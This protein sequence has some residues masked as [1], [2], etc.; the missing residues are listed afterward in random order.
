MEEKKWETYEE[1]AIYL[2][3]QFA[4]KFNLEYFEK[5]QIVEGE[6]S[7]TSWEIDGKGIASQ[8][9]KFIIVECRRYTKSKQNQEK[10]GALAYRILDTGASGGILVSPLGL[11]EG[12]EKVAKAEKIVSVR[13]N[14]NCTTKEYMLSFLNQIAVGLSDGVKITDSC[15][16]EVIRNGRVVEE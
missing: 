14:E 7:G 4:E 10:I 1:V 11:Q 12:A 9:E 16:A 2:L 15:T 8:I 13:L 3:N 6:R 5:K